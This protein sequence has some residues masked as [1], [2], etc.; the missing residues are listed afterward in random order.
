VATVVTLLFGAAAF[1]LCVLNIR[2]KLTPKP[3][4]TTHPLEPALRDIA[5]AVREGRR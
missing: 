5:T 1:V 2:E 3:A 4:P